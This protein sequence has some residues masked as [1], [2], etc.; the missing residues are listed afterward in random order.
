MGQKDATLG[1]HR[2]L[3]F[4]SLFSNRVF[5]VFFFFGG[6]LDLASAPLLLKGMSP[7]KPT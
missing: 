2:W 7:S 4:F 3:F 1:D 5:K 6:T